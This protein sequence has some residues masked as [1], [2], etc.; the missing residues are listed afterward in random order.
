MFNVN[1][2]EE[3]LE[4]FREMVEDEGDDACVRIREYKIGAG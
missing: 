3:I 2:P 1:V 4:K